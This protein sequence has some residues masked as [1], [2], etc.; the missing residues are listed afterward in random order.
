MNISFLFFLN[1]TFLTLFLPA[2]LHEARIIEKIV[3]WA[4]RFQG[5]REDGLW[6]KGHVYTACF[7]AK[8]IAGSEAV[9]SRYGEPWAGGNLE[10]T[11]GFLKVN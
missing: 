11:L 9:S 7:I 3:T 1:I 4:M 8:F 5:T 6:G 2:E 10:E